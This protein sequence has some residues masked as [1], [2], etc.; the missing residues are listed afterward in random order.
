M[1]LLCWDSSVLISWLRGDEGDDRTRSIRSVVSRIEAG[2]YKVAVSSLL[3]VEVL[4]RTMPRYAIERFNRFMQNREMIEILAV[5][6]RIAQ[7]AQIIRN[8]GVHAISVPDAVHVATAIVSK[9]KIFHAFDKDLRQL[10][11]SN[12]VE[13]L[14]ITDCSIPETNL[15]LY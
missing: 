8:R 7:K 14:A 9:A 10:N 2:D 15:S 3:Y 5:D 13:G 11:G 4:E 6:I 1:E 12:E